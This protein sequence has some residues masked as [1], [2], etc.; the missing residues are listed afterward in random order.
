M[1]ILGGL[2]QDEEATAPKLMASKQDWSGYQEVWV[3]GQRECWQKL[4]EI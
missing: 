3:G 4:N 2:N 1:S